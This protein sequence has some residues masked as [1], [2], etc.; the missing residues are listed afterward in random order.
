MMT[1]KFAWAMTPDELEARVNQM[2][3]DGWTLAGSCMSHN[4]ILLQPMT[5]Y[6][7]EVTP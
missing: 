7:P 3:R 2:L 5:R 1:F 4:S 6:E